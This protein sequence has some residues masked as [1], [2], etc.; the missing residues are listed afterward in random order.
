MREIDE[1]Q[2][3]AVVAR[4]RRAHGQMAGVLRMIEE[5]RDCHDVITQ[6]AAVSKAIDRAGFAI[7]AQ[8]MKQ[9]AVDPDGEIDPEALEKLFL[10]LA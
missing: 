4:L 7:I 9:C 5:D 10:S 3:A 1:D 8:G 2:R 6:L